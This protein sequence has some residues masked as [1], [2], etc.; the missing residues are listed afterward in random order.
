MV[1]AGYDDGYRGQAEIEELC[2]QKKT[3]IKDLQ[4]TQQKIYRESEEV[5][6]SIGLYHSRTG[7]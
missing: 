2:Q 1:A 4:E 6:V 5:L 3:V 7:Y